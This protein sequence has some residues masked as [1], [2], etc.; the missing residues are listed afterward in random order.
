[1][2]IRRTCGTYASW[3]T[4]FSLAL[5]MLT[6][7]VASASARSQSSLSD[8]QVSPRDTVAGTAIQFS[9]TYTDDTGAAPKSVQVQIENSVQAL[10]P[11]SSDY[12]HGVRFSVSADVSVGWHAII[13]IA[14]SASGERLSLSAGAVTVHHAAPTPKPSASSPAPSPSQ[15]APTASQPAPTASPTSPPAATPSSGNTGSGAI[16]PTQTPTPN[17]TPTASLASTTPVGPLATP[18]QTAATPSHPTPTATP[19]HPAA[20]ATASPS[21]A[22]AGLGSTATGDVSG[23]SGGQSVDGTDGSA[24]SGGFGGHGPGLIAV[25]KGGSGTGYTGVVPTYLLLNYHAP[26]TQLIVDLAPSITTAAGGTAAW[27]AFVLFGKRRRDGVADDP[28]S[29]LATAAATGLEVA[30]GQGLTT[31]DE[32]LIPRWRRPSLQQVRRTDPLRVVADDPSLSFAASGLQAGEDYERRQIRYRLVG[33]L[34]SPDEL[35]SAEIGVLDRGDEVLLMER[36]GVYW[37]V[38]CPDGRQGW[39]HRMTL[40]DPAHEEAPQ[41]VP[42]EDPAA[43]AV[44][45][46]P[47]STTPNQ[48]YESVVEVASAPAEQADPGFLAAYMQA[49]GDALRAAEQSVAASVPVAE[50]S[51]DPAPAGE[52]G[53]AGERCSGRKTAGTRKAA[54]G[55]RPGTRSRRPSR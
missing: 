20:T 14:T 41:I 5:L 9:V 43:M 51:I 48:P 39:V 23:N 52:P 34:D 7:A 16:G 1:M 32:S 42:W 19:S 13:F 18:R 44:Y 24:G 15:P 31:V 55:S 45:A 35:R 10:A 54:T 25:A 17:A 38:L 4:A 36:R 50:P 53:C 49:R 30:A 22:A 46:A 33:L 37:L 6:L 3:L 21:A 8:A 27:A 11:A 47:D 12:R 40:S 2:P 29:A 26:L 28:E